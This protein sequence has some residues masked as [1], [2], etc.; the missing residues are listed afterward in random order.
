M[1]AAMARRALKLAGPKPRADTEPEAA[2]FWSEVATSAVAS[3]S[4]V[5][6]AVPSAPRRAGKKAKGV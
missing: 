5:P 1:Q 3:A 6:A 4:E 2:T